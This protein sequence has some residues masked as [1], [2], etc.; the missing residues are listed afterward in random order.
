MLSNNVFES[1]SVILS[2]D[3]DGVNEGLSPIEEC[4][5]TSDSFDYSALHLKL[6]YWSLLCRIS[7]RAVILLLEILTEE[8]IDVPRSLYLFKKP[9]VINK[10]NIIKTNVTGN[11]GTF[12]YLSIFE[13]LKFCVA[14]K[15]LT[16][17]DKFCDFSV[18]FGIDGIP[19]FRSSP[20][21]IWPI[22][23]TIDDFLHRPLPVAVFVGLGKPNSA[24]FLT[25]FANELKMFQ[26]YVDI[27][28]FKIRFSKVT[29]ICD[30]PARSFCMGV[31]SHSGYNACPYCRIHGTYCS[32]TKKVIFPFSGVN[33]ESREDDLYCSMSENNQITE[34]PLLHTVSFCDSFPPEYLHSVCLG[35][36]RRLIA[37]YMSNM[38]GLLPCRLSV[39]LKQELNQRVQQFSRSLPHEFKRKP[40]PITE[41]LYFKGTEF[42]TLLLYTG[43]FF[44]KNI[45]QKRYYD[46]FILLHYAIFIYVSP[47]CKHLYANA[48][49][50]IEHFVHQLDELF[51][52]GSQTFNAHSILHL[53]DF[54]N[55]LGPLDS[56][57]AFPFENF[58]YMLKQRIKSG[59]FVVDQTVNSLLK[60]R[61]LYVNCV[62]QPVLV[63]AKFPNNC[64][65]VQ[66]E[67]NY[68]FP[69]I[70]TEVKKENDQYLV[71][72][73]KLIFVNDLYTHPYPSSSVGIGVYKKSKTFVHDCCVICKCVL[74][75][76]SDAYYVFPFANNE[77]HF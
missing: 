75:V 35:Q 56:F 15:L 20:V 55:K 50:C 33:P 53:N 37:S 14:N 66:V 49:A 51:G 23:F 28:D 25:K 2:A 44:F 57:S 1:I 30:A 58:L 7:D 12:A 31:K 6:L 27:C 64:V 76:D 26:D 21:N 46:H 61:S 19:I 65:L 77:T 69:I 67:I 32:T 36:V 68:C 9:N 8:G 29:F 16:L 4:E 59:S 41:F 54:V 71:T 42:R 3:I 24:D 47:R 63:S 40:R 22:L 39:P 13:N 72:G 62:P 60:I 38:H 5:T 48:K 45:L 17:K 10:V 70:V 34:S 74:F 52:S 43:P 18:K 73:Y 11:K